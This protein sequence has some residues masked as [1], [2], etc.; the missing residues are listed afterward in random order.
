MPSQPYFPKQDANQLLWFKNIRPK[1]GGY[2]TPLEIT[3][4]QVTATSAD[5]DYLIW[6]WEYW[7]PTWR[8]YGESATSFRDTVAT[9]TGTTPAE[10]PATPDFGPPADEP[11]EVLPGALTRL[12]KSIARWKTASGYDD[13][14]GQD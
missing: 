13:T 6:T 11:A 14:I 12:F 7:I 10:P 3:A 8:A 9:G 1:F 4:S 2:A 5:L